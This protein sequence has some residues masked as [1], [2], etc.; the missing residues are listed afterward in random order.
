MKQQDFNVLHV[1]QTCRIK[2][3]NQ[4]PLIR[5]FLDTI[6]R[7]H[8]CGDYVCQDDEDNLVIMDELYKI[9]GL[10]I[11][12]IIFEERPANEI[13]LYNKIQ[14]YYNFRYRYK[15]YGFDKMT[16]KEIAEIVCKDYIVMSATFEYEIGE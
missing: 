2:Q 5:M 12:S 13:D 3:R 9:T 11:K 8:R 10:S 15:R 16:R 6:D 7:N 1:T 14:D 4:W